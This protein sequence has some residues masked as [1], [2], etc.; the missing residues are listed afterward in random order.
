MSAALVMAE[1][2]G[3]SR[4][5]VLAVTDAAF[6]AFDKETYQILI[7]V[8][9]DDETGLEI[10]REVKFNFPLEYVKRGQIG[11]IGK[12]LKARFRLKPTSEK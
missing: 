5:A 12:P 6:A 2:A 7:E 10:I 4:R 3:A 11:L 9:D 1:A 8:R